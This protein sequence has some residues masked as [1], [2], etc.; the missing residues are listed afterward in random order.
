MLLY[1]PTTGPTH[2]LS[3]KSLLPMA[4]NLLVSVQDAVKREYDYIVAG[5]YYMLHSCLASSQRYIC[6]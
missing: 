5:A 1:I 4:A 2:H 3:F 6:V